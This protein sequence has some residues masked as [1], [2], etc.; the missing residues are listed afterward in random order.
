MFN[1]GIKLI[2][3][4][5]LVMLL[6]ASSVFAQNAYPGGGWTTAYQVV[7]MG[8]GPANVTV[9]Y[10]NSSGQVQSAATRTISNLAP[11]ASK[12]IVQFS[13]ASNPDYDTNLTSGQYSVVISSDQ[14]LAAITNQQLVPSGSTNYAPTPPFSSYTGQSAGAKQITLPAVMYNWY[15][16][17][18][19][20]YIMNVSTGTAADVDITYVPGLLTGQSTGAS[21]QSDLNQTIPQYASLKLDQSQK[22]SLGASS[23]TFLGRFLGSAVIT[24]DQDVIAVVNQYNTSAYKLMTYNGFA[25]G[26]TS[27]ALP[28]IM[29][30]F[31][32]FY[33]TLL[34]ANPSATLT[35]TV[36]LT[37][38]AD[39]SPGFSQLNPGQTGNTYSASYQVGPQASVTIYDGPGTTASD[40]DDK[41]SRFFGSAKVTSNVPVVS[42]VNV[43]AVASGAAQGG[44]YGG[45]D[46]TG[47]TA[48][49][50][51]PVVAADFYGYYTT[52][53]VQNA[54]DTSG[55]C[56]VSYT[57]D[58]TFSAVKNRTEAYSHNLPAN[59]SFT[60]YEGHAG[61][62]TVG[63]INADA[64]WA[65]GGQRQFL[66]AATVTC[67]VAAV[68]F[69]NEESDVNQ[70]DSMYTFNTFNK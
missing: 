26:S 45:I 3:P 46:L 29:N 19:E 69:V 66:G 39:M 7:N 11:G 12:L 16:Y 48:T 37:Y 14:Q 36:S 30:N 5:S 52:L 25:Q 67:G 49:I 57:S 23:G 18:T 61:G 6:I 10:Y 40:V 42:F 63:D 60:V 4:L 15:G 34:I 43:E 13:N 38:T 21:G 41:F 9:S 31:Y 24:S 70:R 22:A 51:V 17:N 55:T 65:S 1:K 20:I 58:N 2:L 50:V 56:Q 32:G 33:T 28:S 53:I 54:T 44:S 8:D 68:A 64:D 59:G 35:A 27:M 47:A 62:Q